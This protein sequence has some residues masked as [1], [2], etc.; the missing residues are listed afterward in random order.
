[1]RLEVRPASAE[2][3]DSLAE[4]A[5]EAF[6]ATYGSLV[7]PVSVESVVAQACSPAAFRLL[8]ARAAD[9]GQ[10]Q[11]LVAVEDGTIVGFLDFGLEPEGLEL[12]RLYT[13]V[14]LTSRGVGSALLEELESSIPAG[15]TYRIVVLSANERG[16]SFWKRQGF[17]EAHEIDGIKHFEQHR[18]V[19]FKSGSRPEPLLIMDRLVG[20]PAP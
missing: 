11:L 14:G 6:R 4:L 19:R 3:A 1:M 9:S 12:R 13:R 18:G 10:E 15:T 2:D 17:R 8:V 5:G 20:T 16:L 7:D